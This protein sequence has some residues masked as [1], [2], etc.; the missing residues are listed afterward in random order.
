MD[1]QDPRKKP[2]G[3]ANRRRLGG[4]ASFLQTGLPTMAMARIASEGFARAHA[5]GARFS[6]DARGTVTV[7]YAVLI[8]AV[9]LAGA[10]GLIAVG[11]AM[12]ESFDFVRSLLLGPLP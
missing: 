12:V 3:A 1:R 7:E 10:T 9:A 8:G 11:I 5:L 4:L 2:P 6:A